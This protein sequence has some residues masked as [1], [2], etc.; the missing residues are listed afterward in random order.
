[1]T[2]TKESAPY[3]N[4]G[5][6]KE[7]DDMGLVKEQMRQ[8]RLKSVGPPISITQYD[9]GRSTIFKAYRNIC[10]VGPLR[11]LDLDSVPRHEAALHMVNDPKSYLFQYNLQPGVYSSTD[12][13]ANSTLDLNA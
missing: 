6:V 3:V 2:P 11:K 1:M 9:S 5:Y 8:V 13:G 4:V 12:I 10:D 7:V